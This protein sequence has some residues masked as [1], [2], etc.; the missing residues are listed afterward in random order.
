MWNA[1]EETK[2]HK[3]RKKRD[4]IVPKYETERR[5]ARRRAAFP[6]TSTRTAAMEDA[7][8][9]ALQRE[10]RKRHYCER[11]SDVEVEDEVL[12]VECPRFNTIKLGALEEESK[13]LGLSK[14]RRRKERRGEGRGGEQAARTLPPNTLY[15]AILSDATM[16]RR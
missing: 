16:I 15:N 2:P 5:D 12:D 7:V 11:K 1:K 4:T 9:N 10:E 3:E 6:S 14:R 8:E 13:G